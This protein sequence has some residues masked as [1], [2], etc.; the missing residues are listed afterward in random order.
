MAGNSKGRPLFAIIPAAVV[1]I[2]VIIAVIMGIDGYER[3]QYDYKKSTHP[4]MYSE[5]VEKYSA[6]YGLDKYMIYSVIKTE[7][8]FDPEAVSSVGARGLMQIMEETFDWIKFR[9]GDGDEVT[10]EDMFNPEMN[11]RYGAYLYDY[12][13]SYFGHEDL[14]SAAYN[15]GIGTVSGW[16][17]NEEY[18]DDGETLKVIPS[19]T[20]AHYVNKINNAYST[21]YELYVLN[22]RN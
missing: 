2:I 6:E 22:E 12:L 3:V 10:Y 5:F 18:S 21:Y 8:S 7:S 19:G 13:L 15:S 4:L 14:A 20:A 16:L 17:E 11:I 1:V 9:L